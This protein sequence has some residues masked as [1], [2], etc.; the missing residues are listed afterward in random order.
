MFILLLLIIN[1]TL[2]EI[3]Y[4]SLEINNYCYACY[5]LHYTSCNAPSVMCINFIIF[6]EI[7]ITLLI[8]SANNFSL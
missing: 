3:L 5:T 7:V 4:V 6:D 2:V 8:Y 1:K